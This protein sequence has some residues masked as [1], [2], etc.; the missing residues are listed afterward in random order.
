[1]LRETTENLLAGGGVQ[2]I[3]RTADETA[4]A[5][6]A[7]IPTPS[8]DARRAAGVEP[9]DDNDVPPDAA[10]CWSRCSSSSR[11]SPTR[12]P[13]PTPTEGV[14]TLMTLH[15]A[16]GLEFPVVFL[17]GWEDGI[18]PHMRSL[19]DAGRAGRGTPAGLRRHHPRAQRLYVPRR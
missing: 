16:K 15:T 17:T 18:F 7:P 5:G 19:G 4:E 8:G 6:E 14:V 3:T 2:P 10:T 12:T 1:M 9:D 11:W 13:C